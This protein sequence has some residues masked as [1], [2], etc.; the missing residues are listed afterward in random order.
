MK[1]LFFTFCLLGAFHLCFAQS[2]KPIERT[3]GKLTLSIDPRMEVLSAV[4]MISDY[5]VIQKNNAYSQNIDTYFRPYDTLAAVHITDQLKN[6]FTYDAPVLFMLYLSQPKKLSLK[7]PYSQYLIYRAGGEQNLE[8]YRIALHEFA[9][10]SNF[11]NFWNQNRNTYNQILEKTVAACQD[12]DWVKAL[13][14]YYNETQNSYNIII[15]P[16]FAGGYGPRIKAANG[17]YDI[18]ACIS[19]SSIENDIPY[20]DKDG[21]MYYLWH[22]FSHSY[23]NPECEKYQDRIKATQKLFQPLKTTMTKY[24]YGDWGT[25]VNE[26]IVRAI[27]LRLLDLHIGHSAYEQKLQ[28][29]IHYGFL[30]I[31]PILKKLQEYETLKKTTSVTFSAFVPKLIDVLDSLANNNAQQNIRLSFQGPIN[32]VYNHQVAVIYPSN[33]PDTTTAQKVKTYVQ[34]LFNRFFKSSSHLLLADTSALQQS[35]ENYSLVIYG[36][37]VNNLYLNRYQSLLPFSM[38]DHELTAD[39]KYTQPNLKIVSCQPHPQ[40]KELGMVVY[41]SL[42]DED[43][44]GINNVFHGPEDYVIFTD[45]NHILKKGFYQNKPTGKW[46]FTDKK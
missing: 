38:N 16:S 42:L 5:P 45:R 43:L 20:L 27:H 4:Q 35:L 11:K 21:L 34:T 39:Q 32:N 30:Y 22:E 36:N 1:K 31:E 12:I 24:A 3:I 13:E 40:N 18:Y 19:S 46:T 17:K 9:C 44:V 26:H 29:E 23:V 10:K 28:Q 2:L 7:L 8:N 15:S 33:I 25:C 14:E 6:H 37:A 41:S